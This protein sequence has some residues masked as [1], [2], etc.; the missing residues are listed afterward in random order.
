MQEPEPHVIQPF[1][2]T[3]SW[4]R[5]LMHCAIMGVCIILGLMTWYFGKPPNIRF[6][7][8]KSEERL[9]AAIT[10]HIDMAL[11]IRSSV[12]IKDGQPLQA[13]LFKG[14]VYFDIRKE[15]AGMLEIKVGNAI[16]K[17]VGT[18]FSIE[19]LKDG[20]SH[21]AVA[22]GQIKIHVASGVYQINAFEQVDFDDTGISKHQLAIERDI[23]P[24]RTQLQ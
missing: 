15:A 21:A 13:E 4:R 18:R 12:A 11:D 3:F 6:Y 10:P 20:S 14:G 16:I 7:E 9:T 8:T 23:A 19:K 24:W 1:V 22:D 17:D 2:F 5:F